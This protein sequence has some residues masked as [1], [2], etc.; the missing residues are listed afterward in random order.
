MNLATK[1]FLLEVCEMQKKIETLEE[2]KALAFKITE[3]I[4]VGS[5]QGDKLET[6]SPYFGKDVE[7][8]YEIENGLI[9]FVESGAMY[10]LPYFHKVL[11]IFKENG[12]E[13]K[14]MF[15]PFSNHLVPVNELERWEEVQILV[16]EYRKQEFEEICIDYANQHNISKIPQEILDKCDE[17]PLFAI[18]VNHLYSSLPSLGFNFEL[19]G[20][21]HTDGKLCSFTYRNGHQYVTDRID[22][23]QALVDAGYSVY[24]P[25]RLF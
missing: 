23:Y 13:C 8:G 16:N 7:H 14:K 12:F 19:I 5:Q 18:T 15:V 1:N 9:V 11:D 24:K 4:R 3:P 10:V 2:L 21:Y 20:K 22:V 17:K 6:I 25:Q